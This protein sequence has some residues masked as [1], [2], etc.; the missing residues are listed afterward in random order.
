MHLLI[1]LI[2]NILV[3]KLIKAKYQYLLEFIFTLIY[4]Y[5]LSLPN[6]GLIEYLL[7]ISFY[8]ATLC[9]IFFSEIYT[10]NIHIIGLLAIIIYIQR[11]IALSE[12]GVAFLLPLIL[13][14]INKKYKEII[15]IGDLEVLAYCA[16]IMGLEIYDAFIFSYLLLGLYILLSFPFKKIDDAYPLIPFLS[17]AI[18]IIY[19]R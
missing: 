4:L 5:F 10:I 17:L 18:L 6:I 12:L 11:P 9:D 16:L 1:I 8:I 3:H 7:I 14:I 13:L 2:I 19:F 15:G